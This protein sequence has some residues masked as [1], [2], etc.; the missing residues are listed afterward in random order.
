MDHTRVYWGRVFAASTSLLDS[1]CSWQWFKSWQTQGWTKPRGQ[2]GSWP[3]RGGVWGPEG[4][5][6]SVRVWNGHVSPVRHGREIEQ[7]QLFPVW[8]VSK[9]Q[10]LSQNQSKPFATHLQ[11]EIQAKSSNKMEPTYPTT[12]YFFLFPEAVDQ[13][14]RAGGANLR[15]HL[16]ATEARIFSREK[17]DMVSREKTKKLLLYTSWLKI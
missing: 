5:W 12:S 17:P 9:V 11:S 16:E 4:R 1:G 13:L 2:N 15:R 14:F 3:T 7:N 10:F 8:N 6:G